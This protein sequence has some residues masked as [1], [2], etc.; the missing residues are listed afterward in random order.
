MTNHAQQLRA[1]EGSLSTF[2]Q[3][4]KQLVAEI[5]LPIKAEL[6]IGSVGKLLSAARLVAIDAPFRAAW[7][8]P[9][10]AT[11]IVAN[12]KDAMAKLESINAIEQS[13]RDRIKP[14]NL[15]TLISEVEDVDEL[16]HSWQFVTAKVSAAQI[17]NLDGL[18][19]QLTHE[20][21][22]LSRIDADLKSLAS[23]LHWNGGFVPT[24]DDARTIVAALPALLA[25]GAYNGS[26]ADSEINNVHST[27]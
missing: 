6:P 8:E 12:A 10:R 11:E 25:A 26:W 16:K 23:A 22:R 1:F 2:E 18:D 27:P 9:E 5:K 4:L 19:R 14:D 3:A 20:Q 21:Q 13:V 7:F 24:L 17:E 15:L